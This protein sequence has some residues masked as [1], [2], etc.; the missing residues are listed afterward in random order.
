MD[1]PSNAE[2][3]DNNLF[4]EGLLLQI[5][6]QRVI[7]IIGPEL[8][9]VQLPGGAV[10]LYRWAAKRLAELLGVSIDDLPD[11]F[12]LNDIVC[13][14]LGARG[15]VGDVYIALATIML[16]AEFKVPT[17]LDQLASIT[18]F[19][20]YVTTTFDWLLAEALKAARRGIVPQVISY[21]PKK[22]VDLPAPKERLLSPT[23]YQLFGKVSA[24]PEYAV[25]DEDLLE[26]PRHA[27]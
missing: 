15:D 10:P 3:R 2:E 27:Q 20:L 4:W 1:S 21:S 16:G 19:N 23:I 9:T 11:N 14:H 6:E 24:A 13:R 22:P 25:S 18:D 26:Q 17:A 7:P 12:S 8:L 5:E